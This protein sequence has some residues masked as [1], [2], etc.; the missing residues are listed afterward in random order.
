M[1]MLSAQI[2]RTTGL[3]HVCKGYRQHMSKLEDNADVIC[4][5]QGA[6]GVCALRALV[7]VVIT[8]FALRATFPPST[9]GSVATVR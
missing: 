8:C 3:L 9:R 7:I 2:M 6:Y 4:A 5:V 1:H